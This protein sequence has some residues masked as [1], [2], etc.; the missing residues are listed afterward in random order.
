[1]IDVAALNS[2][3]KHFYRLILSKHPEWQAAVSLYHDLWPEHTHR[4]RGTLWLE[5]PVQNSDKTLT[6]YIQETEALVEIEKK[7]QLFLWKPE[8][9]IDACQAIMN[10]V[11]R[12]VQTGKIRD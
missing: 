7:E 1:M 11:E 9:C 12:G 5:L 8:E 10:C 6:A 2:G 3:A 4:P